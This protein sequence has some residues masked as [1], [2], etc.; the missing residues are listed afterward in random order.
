MPP[1]E[2]VEAANAICKF[3]D[4]G[5]LS[6]T[7]NINARAMSMIDCEHVRDI[8]VLNIAGVARRAAPNR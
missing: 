7:L 4:V 1:E 5:L 8:D 6:F 2:I 3:G